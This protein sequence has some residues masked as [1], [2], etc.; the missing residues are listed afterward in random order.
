MLEALEKIPGVNPVRPEGG[1]YFITN[2]KKLGV[3]SPDF[4]TRLLEEK[5]VAATPMV[6]WGSDEFGYDHVR[7]IFTNETEDRLQTA[8]RLIQEF[9]REHYPS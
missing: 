3:K 4:C 5:N 6:A 2:I 7:F 1:Y 9:I 8:G